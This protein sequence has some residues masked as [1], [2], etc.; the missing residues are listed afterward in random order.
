MDLKQLIQIPTP[1][2]AITGH[3]EDN[4]AL[5]FLDKSENRILQMVKKFER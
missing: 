2:P 4:G 3:H 5:S 1:V